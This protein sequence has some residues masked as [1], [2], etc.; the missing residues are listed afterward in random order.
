M[1]RRPKVSMEART[2]VITAS[3]SVTSARLATA[4]PPFASISFTTFRASS[5][6]L[7]AFTTTFAPPSAS[8]SAMARP[9]LRLGAGHQR[10]AAFELPAVIHGLS[11]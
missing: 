9:M 11:P 8:A 1:S 5:R 3:S 6:D 10:D 4:L 2:I 7:R